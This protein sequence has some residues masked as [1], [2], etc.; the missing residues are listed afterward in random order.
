[1]DILK[2]AGVSW[3]NK[4]IH[5]AVLREGELFT[6]HQD[7]LEKGSTSLQSDVSHRQQD[8]FTSSSAKDQLKTMCSLKSEGE[9]EEEEE[10]EEGEEEEEEEEENEEDMFKKLAQHNQHL[11]RK[12]RKLVL[13]EKSIN[14][15]SF[16]TKLTSVLNKSQ[17]H[18][19]TNDLI[20]SAACFFEETE[21][22]VHLKT[23][24]TVWHIL[25][26]V[27]SGSLLFDWLKN[28][29]TEFCRELLFH[30]KT[31]KD[32]TVYLLLKHQAEFDEMVTHQELCD[33]L[34]NSPYVLC[35]MFEFKMN[36]DQGFDYLQNY[37]SCQDLKELVFQPCIYLPNEG[38]L[39]DVV[40]R[41]TERPDINLWCLFISDLF[42]EE[43]LHDKLC[44]PFRV[45]DALI[46][47]PCL[48]KRRF[49]EKFTA[50][51]NEIF[52]SKT[53]NL[54][55]TADR[56]YEE[57]SQEELTSF[58]FI[59]DL[60]SFV[61]LAYPSDLISINRKS[62]TEQ[63]AIKDA[64]WSSSKEVQEFFVRRSW[65]GLFHTVHSDPE[66]LQQN[67]IQTSDAQQSIAIH[68]CN[69]PVPSPPK[70]GSRNPNTIR[71][72]CGKIL[73]E[74][75]LIQKYFDKTISRPTLSSMC[76]AFRSE[77]YNVHCVGY[78]DSLMGVLLSSIA[79][80]GLYIGFASYDS[81]CILQQVKS[82]GALFIDWIVNN[83]LLGMDIYPRFEQIAL[84]GSNAAAKVAEFCCTLQYSHKEFSNEN[85]K[86][87]S[88]WIKSDSPSEESSK[89]MFTT[90]HNTKFLSEEN[91]IN[92]EHPGI[93]E[94]YLLSM[95]QNEQYDAA[96]KMLIRAVS[97][98]KAI[99]VKT[100][101]DLLVKNHG[102]GNVLKLLLM[103]NEN[104]ASVWE[105]VI[106]NTQKDAH[107]VSII[108]F[109]FFF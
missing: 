75:E 31:I 1:V 86:A 46:D 85:F 10:K 39:F 20:S 18:M 103:P 54:V 6:E 60:Q 50:E 71:R 90:F 106:S 47:F 65:L 49:G 97:K 44:G 98:G 88:F 43:E 15:E 70:L 72:S 45:S 108:C 36:P 42:T 23:F 62:Q 87:V 76:C 67:G 29:A 68:T 38:T 40:I 32:C 30:P 13:A 58:N 94:S 105:Q 12:T 34:S 89:R 100:L 16:V 55:T 3:A 73:L 82:S 19:K 26:F 101:L 57:G 81:E 84:T 56:K 33:I 51:P 52:V 5:E 91:V 107:F 102:R 21:D 48:L 95:Q 14:A 4:R 11:V 77:G 63:S 8:N 7:S 78:S 35:C 9:E 99:T 96:K 83:I 53:G 104:L 24:S 74:L 92:M 80:S 64:V 28:N 17:N 66:M 41:N 61:K 59:S 37:T 79:D 22:F 27:D 2:N 25:V 69:L 109:L 93:I